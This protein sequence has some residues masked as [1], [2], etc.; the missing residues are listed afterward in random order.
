MSHIAIGGFKNEDWVVDEFNNYSGWGSS[1][2]C[3]MGHDAPVKVCAQ[4]TRKMGYTNKADVLVLVDDDVEWLSVKK[5]S[6]NFNQI[7]KRRVDTF[8][9][10]WNMPDVVA[11]S[12]R[13]YCGETGFRPEGGSTRDG[14]RFMMDELD[15]TQ[16]DVVLD[17]FNKKRGQI[18]RNVMA[19]RGKAAARWML[20]IEERRSRPYRSVI[21]PIGVVVRHCVGPALITKNGNLRL[22]KITIQRKGGDAGKDT[23]QMLQFKFSPKDLFEI[24]G[25]HIT[26]GSD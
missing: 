22:G 2:L 12:L 26:Y 15:Q 14:R 23:A 5:F 6:A 21:L 20:V 24:E 8:A 1:W 3:A 4:T 19:G 7:D 16:Q 25:A 17:F 13:M 18:I 9:N 10:M 11:N